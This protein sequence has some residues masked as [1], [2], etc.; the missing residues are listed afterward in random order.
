MLIAGQLALQADKQKLETQAA[1]SFIE[2]VLQESLPDTA[3]E[4]ALHDG[5]LLCRLMQTLEPGCITKV[6]RA[7]TFAFKPSD[8]VFFF[9]L[10]A[11]PIFSSILLYTPCTSLAQVSDST[12]NF[13]QMENIG[14]FLSAAEAYGVQSSDSFQTV[15]LF[16]KQNVFQVVNTIIHLR[17]L[18]TKV[19]IG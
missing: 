8:W 16:E 10:S 18:A 9:S 11:S 13:Q 7:A 19:R 2:G 5:V 14:K 4:D 15:D 6:R 17:N 3:I 12:M 1:R